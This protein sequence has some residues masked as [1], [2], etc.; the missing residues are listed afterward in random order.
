MSANGATWNAAT[1][2]TVRAGVARASAAAGWR[3]SHLAARLNTPPTPLDGAAQ[4]SPPQRTLA[5]D[6]D[7]EWAWCFGHLPTEPTRVMDFGAGNG[8][9]SLGAAF[10]GH[11]VVAVDLEP[12]SF[13]FDEP[14][15][16]YRRGNFLEMAFGSEAFGHIVNCSSI[17]HVGLSGRYGS[18][19]A[20]DGDLE[21]MRKMEQ[22]LSPG[23]TMSLV[24]PM[25]RDAIFAPLHRVY[26]EKRLPELIGGLEILEEQ[27]RAKADG[28]RWH[29]VDRATALSEE[30]SSSYY[31]IGLFSLRRG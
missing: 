4:G 18:P 3:L 19:D 1:R 22:L 5:G 8:F 14:R 30:G 12:Q 26:G 2:R 24:V 17:E 21:A 31:A 28:D 29:P 11:D 23:G 9:V 15:I 6:R 13:A 10:R 20:P 25:G 7:V 27:Y 16:E